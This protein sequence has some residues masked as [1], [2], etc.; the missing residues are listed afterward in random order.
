VKYTKEVCELFDVIVLNDMAALS[1]DEND[2]QHKTV[3]ALGWHAEPSA[4]I[5][6]GIVT[7]W[8]DSLEELNAFCK[9][10]IKRFRKWADREDGIVPDASEWK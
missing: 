10:N 6:Y 8:F 2:M 4:G 5:N 1:D 3:Y 7:N 9:R